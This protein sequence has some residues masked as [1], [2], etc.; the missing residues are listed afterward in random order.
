[1]KMFFFATKE[2]KRD[3]QSRE[4][5]NREKL[6]RPYI[7]TIVETAEPECKQFVHIQHQLLTKLLKS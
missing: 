7:K 3:K 6:V 4:Q 2:R 1:M 5:S